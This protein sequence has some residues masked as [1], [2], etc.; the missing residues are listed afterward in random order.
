MGPDRSG[1]ESPYWWPFGSIVIPSSGRSGGLGLAVVPCPFLAPLGSIDIPSSWKIR[2][3]RLTRKCS[4]R[5]PTPATWTTL[6]GD[7]WTG[8]AWTGAPAKAS[9]AIRTTATTPTRRVRY[10]DMETPLGAGLGRG[11][12]PAEPTPRRERLL[13]TAK[14]RYREPHREATPARSRPHAIQ[15]AAQPEREGPMSVRTLSELVLK[16]ASYNKPD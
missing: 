14:V 15:C 6:A 4:S 5:S 10:E 8:W 7:G 12:M 16:A 3:Q 11:G 1:P 9:R 13:L 2:V